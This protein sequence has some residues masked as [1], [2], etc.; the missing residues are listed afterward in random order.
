[1]KFSCKIARSSMGCSFFSQLWP[2]CFMNKGC[3]ML[4]VI[5]C[6]VSLEPDPLN[7]TLLVADEKLWLLEFFHFQC[8]SGRT[9]WPVQRENTCPPVPGTSVAVRH[10][11]P[12]LKVA[13]ANHVGRKTPPSGRIAETPVRSAATTARPFISE[14]PATERDGFRQNSRHLSRRIPSA[15]SLQV[16]G[17][18][19]TP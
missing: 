8:V 12:T 4:Y 11:T 13:R 9:P 6:A 16:H 14:K 15:P 7:R 19:C 18:V 2:T 10:R 5:G 17:S 1:M 3:R